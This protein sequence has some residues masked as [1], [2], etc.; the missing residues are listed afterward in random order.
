[1]FVLNSFRSKERCVVVVV[2]VCVRQSVCMF[3]SKLD[4][5]HTKIQTYRHRVLGFIVSQTC[6]RV[7]TFSADH[8]FV[9]SHCI[10]CCDVSFGSL[11]ARKT[12][13]T[14]CCFPSRSANHNGPFEFSGRK[15]LTEQHTMKQIKTPILPAMA[16]KISH[17]D[18]DSS[19][20]YQLYNWRRAYISLSIYHSFASVFLSSV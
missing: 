8:A 14:N 3:L 18:N 2:V 16:N 4:P 11:S 17:N 19:I 13:F 15:H 7:C 9:W 6:K 12:D 10:F 20:R 5:T 1:M